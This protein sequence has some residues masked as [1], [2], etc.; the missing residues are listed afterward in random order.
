M[1]VGLQGS[2]ILI[3]NPNRF[4]LTIRGR[5]R[6]LSY[7]RTTL[8]LFL[9]IITY[10]RLPFSCKLPLRS[11]TDYLTHGNTLTYLYLDPQLES[12]HLFLHLVFNPI[13]AADTPPK[14][15]GSIK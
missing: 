1:S 2:C 6:L 14:A 9:D 4:N 3:L 12:N 15:K 5:Q 10:S 11:T 8:Q 13:C 7:T